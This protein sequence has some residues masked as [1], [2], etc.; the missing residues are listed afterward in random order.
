MF[1]DSLLDDPLILGVRGERLRDLAL[2]GA[3]LRSEQPDE[4]AAAAAGLAGSR[5]RAVVVIGAEA[6]LVRAVVEPAGPVPVIAWPV[7]GLPP[8]VGPLDLVVVLAG[9]DDRLLPVC[10]E[11]SRRGAWLFVVA[12]RNSPILDESGP[13][14]MLVTDDDDPLVAALL[15]LKVLDHVGLGPAVDLEAVA[16]VL[17]AVAEECGPRHG[18]GANPA[19][20]LACAMADVVPLVWG[21]SALAGR[22][23]RRVAQAFR[24]ATRLPALAADE[25]ALAT[26]IEGAGPRDVFADPFE[27]ES[28]P[29]RFGLLILDDG[30][31]GRRAMDLVALAEDHHVRVATISRTEGGPVLRYAGLRHQGSF[32]AAYLGLAT[33]A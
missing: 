3:R 16:G 31:S 32:V 7:T 29:T 28:A 6:H 14:T 12:P 21:G 18:L 20:D 15:A 27:D 30:E 22:A 13:A 25:S 9:P 17:D 11:A 23:S 1:D 2:A 8:W 26:L 10:L 19:K 5:P 33:L 4:V 24:E